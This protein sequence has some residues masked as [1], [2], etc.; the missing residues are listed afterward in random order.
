MIGRGW[1]SDVEAGSAL[2]SFPALG[3]APV[4]W[5]TLGGHK[6]LVLAA[7]LQWV[8]LGLISAFSG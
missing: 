6:C 1:L 5:Q 7:K 3:P 2:V 4:L 8:W